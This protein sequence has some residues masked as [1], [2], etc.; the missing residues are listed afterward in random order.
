LTFAFAHMGLQPSRN[1]RRLPRR[2]GWARTRQGNRD[3]Q[4]DDVWKAR[5]QLQRIISPIE[6]FRAWPGAGTM[7]I[8][9]SSKISK[10]RD[11]FGRPLGLLK[12]W[13]TAVK[14]AF[15]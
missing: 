7:T 15:Y 11:R 4:A 13:R 2:T 14:S 5:S 3:A 8:A 12:D 10:S 6:A 9:A 1:V